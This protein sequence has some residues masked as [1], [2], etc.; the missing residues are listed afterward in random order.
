M[1]W[2][3]VPTGTTATVVVTFGATNPSAVQNHIAVYAVTGSSP[4]PDRGGAWQ[5]ID[6]DPI[7][8]SATDLYA[9]RINTGGAGLAICA[10]AT[11]GTTRTW[12]GLTKDIDQTSG[13]GGFRFSTGKDGTTNSN[14]TITVSGG[15][16]EDAALTWLCFSP[17]IDTR[18]GSTAKERRL[19]LAQPTF[20]TQT[21]LMFRL[22]AWLSVI[23][24][25]SLQRRKNNTV[26]NRLH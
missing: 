12:T 4:T 23:L 25:L 17:T 16:G 15:N 1:F 22:P 20:K 9:P 24:L 18:G 5:D 7:D 21:H 6:A 13:T 11:E 3:A 19:H 8:T 10:D 14:L 2:L 26:S